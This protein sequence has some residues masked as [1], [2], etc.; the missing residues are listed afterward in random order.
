MAAMRFAVPERI[1]KTAE[2]LYSRCGSTIRFAG[3]QLGEPLPGYDGNVSSGHTKPRA[4]RGSRARM[5]DVRTL[6]ECVRTGLVW[7]NSADERAAIGNPYGTVYSIIEPFCSRHSDF[8]YRA[9]RRGPITRLQPRLW[10][11]NSRLGNCRT[12]GSPAGR[13]LPRTTSPKP[14][15]T[16][17]HRQDSPDSVIRDRAFADR[18]R[19]EPA[20]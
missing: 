5:R 10:D 9:G 15:G 19:I 4:A 2:R 17:C 20:Q 6:G 11:A 7:P 1:G 3:Y 12:I 16:P 14:S 8:F 13:S 18:L